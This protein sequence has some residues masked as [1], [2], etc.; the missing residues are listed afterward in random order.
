MYCIK[1][2]RNTDFINNT[3]TSYSRL[4]DLD[5]IRAFILKKRKEVCLQ[6][7]IGSHYKKGILVIVYDWDAIFSNKQVVELLNWKVFKENGIKQIK[8]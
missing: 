2:S 5:D 3:F 6:H 4:F 7:K 1:T 8:Q